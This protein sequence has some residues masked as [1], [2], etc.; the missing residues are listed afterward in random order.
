[1]I[2]N[3]KALRKA[4]YA[5]IFMLLGMILIRFWGLFFMAPTFIK[6]IYSG[7]IYLSLLSLAFTFI[8]LKDSTKYTKILFY[9]LIIISILQ[10]IRSIF[11]TDPSMYAFG[12]KWITLFG[13]EYTALIFAPP[14]YL[15]L[16]NI[17]Q[18][19]KLIIK[20]SFIYVLSCFLMLLIG[21]NSF[22]YVSIFLLLFWPYVNKKYKF[23]IIITYLMTLKFAFD[24]NRMF[25]ITILF[26]LVSYFIVYILKEKFIKLFTI[27]TI[28]IIPIF[29]ISTL[30]ID[31]Y[32]GNND[33]Y[34]QKIQQHLSTK[35]G[36]E[37]LGTDTR[38]FLYVEMAQ[39]LSQT[40][41]WIFGKGALSHYYS[42]YFDNSNNGKYG[43]ISSEVP[44]LNFLLRGGIIYTSLYFSLLL[45]AVWCA[46]KYGKNKFIKSISIINT[47]WI[48]NSFIGDIT[49][50]TF[51]HIVFFALVGC[52]LNKAWLN[53]TD[54]EIKKLLKFKT[55][56]LTKL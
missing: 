17:K 7:L 3:S 48:F 22:A 43:R 35:K 39:D 36:N 1:M 30:F 54:E 46:L 26:A 8:N 15:I 55:L 12:N 20:S 6:L 25:F 24:G 13:N 45:Y 42:F 14:L 40:N 44:F 47:G 37:E 41:S 19:P 50:C 31:D 9:S 16:S 49:G 2:Y 27:L 56:S 51:Y 52:C 34:F 5:V 53:Y 18:I 4:K 21:K 23:L 38:T 11:N 33:S 10:I 29:F 28:S 32:K